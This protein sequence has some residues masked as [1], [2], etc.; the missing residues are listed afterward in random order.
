MYCERHRVTITTA[1]GGAGLGYT[2]V[3]SGRVLAIIYTKTDFANGVD[4]TITGESTGQTIWTEENVNAS[5]RRQPR[6]AT[7]T[8]AG[9]EALY[10]AAG[11]GVLDHVYVAAERIG[12]AVAAGGD[13]HV[14]TFD[15]LIG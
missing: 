2:P 3:V 5:T 7:H 6:Q 11:Q 12:I 13:A 8:T 10:A 15:V 14:G 9:V 1:V 4:F